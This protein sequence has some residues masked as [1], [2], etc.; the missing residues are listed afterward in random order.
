MVETIILDPTGDLDQA[1]KAY[2]IPQLEQLVA[3]LQIKKCKRYFITSIPKPMVMRKW[4]ADYDSDLR[5]AICPSRMEYASAG[6]RLLLIGRFMGSKLAPSKNKRLLANRTYSEQWIAEDVEKYRVDGKNEFTAFCDLLTSHCETELAELTE[7]T[8]RIRNTQAS[9]RR[10]MQRLEHGDKNA[11]KFPY[12]GGYKRSH[13]SCKYEMA[14]IS[15]SLGGY[16]DRPIYEP[17]VPQ[18]HADDDYA[19]EPVTKKRKEK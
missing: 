13:L 3:L 7:K 8:F 17:P 9:V 6:E 5:H 11:Y 14:V 1:L 2:S 15:R 18:V 19:M 16:I 12:M 10:A 4:M